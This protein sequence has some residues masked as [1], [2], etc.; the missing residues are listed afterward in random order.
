MSFGEAKMELLSTTWR[1]NLRSSLFSVL[2]ARL[3]TR[4]IC[5]LSVTLSGVY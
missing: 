2:T 1:G 5:A 3:V 4:L